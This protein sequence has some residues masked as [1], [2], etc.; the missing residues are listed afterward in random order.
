LR[1]T[2]RKGFSFFVGKGIK[3]YSKPADDLISL[4]KKE[5]RISANPRL[6]F[7]PHA[8][9]LMLFW[10]FLRRA[11]DA[12]TGNEGKRIAKKSRPTGYKSDGLLCAWFRSFRV[13][14]R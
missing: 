10:G 7:S 9:G 6:Y 14:R 11:D 12:Y 3:A 13:A 5:P 4:I 2:Q 8:A 1:N